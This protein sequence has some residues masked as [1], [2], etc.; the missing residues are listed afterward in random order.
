MLPIENEYRRFISMLGTITKKR[1][2]LS[3]KNIDLRNASEDDVD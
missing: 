3:E 1:M 2:D